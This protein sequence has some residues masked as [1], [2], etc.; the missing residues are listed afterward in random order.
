[1]ANKYEYPH[2][3]EWKNEL[4]KVFQAITTPGTYAAWEEL[5]TTPPAGLHVD[6]V[7]DIAM[8]LAEERVRE[9]IV[10]ARQAPYGRRSETLVDLSVRNTWEIDGARLQFLDPAWKGYLHTLAKRVAILLGV[11][12]PI[13]LDLYKLLIYEEGA[14][15]KPHT[16]TERTPGMFGTLV[17]CLPSAHTGGEVVV[18]HN[19]Q[20]KTLRTSDATQSFACWYS[21]VAHEVLPVKS[22][23]RCVLTYNL[24]TQPD[25]PR[26]AASVVESQ[27]DPL[28]KMIGSWLEDL[29]ANSSPNIPSCLYHTLDYS[30]T[31][32][33]I[34]LKA[35]KAEDYARVQTLRDLTDELPF[36]VYLALIERTEQGETEVSFPRKRP[37]FDCD[38]PEDEDAGYH[39]IEEVLEEGHL[40]KSL[41]TLD[42]KIVARDYDLKINNF[43]EDE[44]FDGIDG[45]EDHFEPYQGNWGPSAV[46]LYQW[47]ALVILP[48]QSLP[49]YLAACTDRGPY[50]DP[51]KIPVTFFDWAKEWIDT[52]PEAERVEKYRTW[53][54][55]IIHRNRCVA[56]RFAFVERVSNLI[57]NPALPEA[58]FPGKSWAD[59]MVHDI[60]KNLLQVTTKGDALPNAADG[61]VV[62]SAIFKLNETWSTKLELIKS[63]F[64]AFPQ[65]AAAAFLFSLISQ[66]KTLGT[67]PDLPNSETMELCR[68]LSSRVFN[69]KRTPSKIMTEPPKYAFEKPLV[70]T[71][72]D[73]IRFACDLHDLSTDAND[74]LESF[75]LQINVHCPKFPGEGIR[76]VW[77][78]FLSQLIPVLVSRSISIDTPLYQQ[79]ARQLI[80]YGD[81]KLGPA[82]QA[83]P[84]TP[85]P[86]ITC[87]CR[88]CLS[89][90]RFLK[91]PHQVVGRFPLPQARRH[92]VYQSLDDPGF[93]C[94]RKTEHKGKPYTL[95]ITKR[96][97]LE[98]KIK[99]WKDRR[100]E[101]YA[102][103]AKNIHQDLLESLLGKQGATLVRSVAGVQQADAR[104]ATQTN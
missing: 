31:E 32:A 102:P 47:S 11:D 82:P 2:M 5:A 14:M 8:P 96:L 23:Y 103:L 3:V 60:I 29:A 100:S 30:Y 75:I 49:K 83:D 78:P 7:G 44:P 6:G 46:H 27:K 25:Q 94:I 90:K 93:D 74:L 35:L 51:P 13:Q 66:F 71:A 68:S 33:A 91:D 45:I 81:E 80:K 67:A 41:H 22:G 73:L 72:Q 16:D 53:I 38:E 15:F 50:D 59:G 12:G 88:D 98:N 52:L 58:A 17:I 42:G 79:L 55:S 19:G 48:H 104:S 9:L 99:E 34:S 85:R 101:I 87:P 4:L 77:I 84:N 65:S 18:K 24:V 36:Q 86:Q 56:E 40:V 89:L 69:L 1:M 37:R 26:P 76:K 21:D 70:V 39:F 62:V 28:R 57:G 43:I 97:T 63:L 20:S 10:N 54:P 95:I 61:R 92:H 64:D